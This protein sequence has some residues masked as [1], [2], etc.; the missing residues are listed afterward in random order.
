M[1]W[2][3]L[4]AAPI[5][6]ST[7][8]GSVIERGFH[9]GFCKWQQRCLL[10]GPQ[11]RY[12]IYNKQIVGVQEEADA[13]KTLA[14]TRIRRGR[15]RV[16][17]DRIE[18][19]VALGHKWEPSVARFPPL[20]ILL[21]CTSQR[22]YREQCGKRAHKGCG[23]SIFILSCI[24]LFLPQHHIRRREGQMIWGFLRL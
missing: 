14:E 18:V 19:Q 20:V 24:G 23:L 5:S 2:F 15:G 1:R 4:Q 7:A 11:R 12:K 21:I 17:S 13:T 9:T 3:V 8:L 10:V 16:P 22:A 6:G